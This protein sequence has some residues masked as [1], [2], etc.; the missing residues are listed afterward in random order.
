MT[1][2]D[3]MRRIRL[4]LVD[5]DLVMVRLLTNVID[6]SF[7]DEIEM[8]SWTNPEK[9]RECLEHE[10][11][12]VLITDLKMPGVDGLSL[13]RCAKRRN[14]LTQVIFVTGHSS[15]HALVDALESGATDY[16][17]KP[18][19]HSELVELL[20]QALKRVRRWRGALA[21]SL[22]SQERRSQHTVP[23]AP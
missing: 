9:A 16:L 11:F 4:L 1:K 10:L 23:V 15:S 2:T 12:D 20:A 6:R 13:L 7:G 21:G 14:P 19:V 3:A 8:Q 18:V 17:L 5:D 22:H